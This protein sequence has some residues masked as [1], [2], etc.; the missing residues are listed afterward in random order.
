MLNTLTTLLG[1][2]LLGLSLAAPPG[3]MNAII[4]E[5]SVLGGWKS[6]FKAGLGAM[7][8][9]FCFLV[10]S[11]IG[12]TT[13]VTESNT[14]HGILLGIGGFLMLYFAYESIKN[15]NKALIGEEVGKKDKGFQKTFVL[16]ITN[17][18]QI[19]WW[20]SAGIALLKP[21]SVGTIGYQI[22]TGTPLI[23][24]GLFLGI[25]IWIVS[26]PLAL[27][28]AKQKFQKLEYIIAYAS[29]IILLLFSLIFFYNSLSNLFRL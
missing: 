15:A 25:L 28:L 6:G 5:Q 11:L 16:A 27:K 23:V 29:A 3:P 4:A 13:I 20:L 17:P 19:I 14:I 8:A 22:N 10:F 9:D 2:L 26:F 12:L 1:G 7:T 24:F 18:Y 21:G